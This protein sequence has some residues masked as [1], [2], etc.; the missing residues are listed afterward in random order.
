[1]GDCRNLTAQCAGL[2]SSGLLKIQRPSRLRD[3]KKAGD[4]GRPFSVRSLHNAGLMA[5]CVVDFRKPK[6]L[7]QP[8]V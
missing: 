7:K 2:P 1:V 3:A 6:E 5:P 8:D 4:R